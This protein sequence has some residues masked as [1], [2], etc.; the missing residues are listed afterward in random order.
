MVHNHNLYVLER[1]MYSSRDMY[2]T[3]LSLFIGI[4]LNLDQSHA[5]IEARKKSIWVHNQWFDD[6]HVDDDIDDVHVDDAIDEER[7]EIIES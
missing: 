2:D 6:V 1:H 4:R 3:F 7:W 5:H